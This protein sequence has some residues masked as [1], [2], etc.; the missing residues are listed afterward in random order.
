MQ[1]KIVY[2]VSIAISATAA[3]QFQDAV[4]V[5][6]GTHPPLIIVLLEQGLRIWEALGVVLLTLVA[7]AKEIVTV[8]VTANRDCIVTNEMATRKSHGVLLVAVEIRRVMTIAVVKQVLVHRLRH[9]PHTGP[10]GL[11]LPPGLPQ[12]EGE[13]EVLLASGMPFFSATMS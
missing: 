8:T 13:E 10:P 12:Q 11:L 9:Q 1:M 3:R 2:L 4:L 7:C 6:Q 5:D